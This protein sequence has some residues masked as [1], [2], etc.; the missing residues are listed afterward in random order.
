VEAVDSVISHTISPEEESMDIPKSMGDINENSNPLSSEKLSRSVYSSSS[1][2]L[3]PGKLALIFYLNS[4]G[5]DIDGIGVRF[6]IG[7]EP[8]IRTYLL[9]VSSDF[10]PAEII[11]T[12]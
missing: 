7:V 3:A 9:F 10:L 6:R 1:S 2:G 11:F 8:R 5:I 12:L 4:P